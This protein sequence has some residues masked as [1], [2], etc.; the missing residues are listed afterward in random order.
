[1]SAPEE[2]AASPACA[3]QLRSISKTFG[4]QRALDHV[5]LDVRSGEI[6]A[7]MG[8]NGSGKSTVVKVLGGYHHPDTGTALVG[9]RPFQ[10]GAAKAAELAGLRFVHQDLGLV[11]DLSVADNFHLTAGRG[12]WTVPLSKKKE[13]ESAGAALREFGYD[14]DP[15]RRVESLTS[16]ERTAVAIVRAVSGGVGDPELLVL[17]EPTA[18]LPHADAEIMYGALRG[19]VAKGRSVLFISHHLDEVLALADRV[20]VLRDGRNVVTRDTNGLDSSELAALM[21]GR[22]LAADEAREHES[23]STRGRDGNPVLLVEDLRTA[24]AQGVGFE[25]YSGEIVGIAGLTGSG[26]EELAP[27]LAGQIDRQGSMTVDVVAVKPGRPR[28]ALAAG[29]QYL[30]AERRRDALFAGAS[31]R[32]NTVISN[33]DSVSRFKRVV[34]KLERTE[35]S[36]WIDVLDV[37]PGQVE[38]SA[39]ELSGG[40]QQKVVLGRLLRMDPRVLVLDEPTQG[41]DIGAKLAI[42]QLVRQVAAGGAAVVV[43]SSDESELAALANRVLV[44]KKGRIGT[45]LEGAQITAERIEEEQLAVSATASA[46]PSPRGRGLVDHE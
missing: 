5:D 7:L 38:K 8:P 43:C 3:L 17:D 35:T 34:R 19:L 41:V 30:P 14:I 15:G 22:A 11:E 40:N 39:V 16:A 26:R 24:A 44:M 31:I 28:A 32:E 20:T 10:L 6:H 29:V 13:A 42:H 1:M 27:A 23:A 36:K 45:V 46:S 12:R 2:N 37:R 33:L 4:A 18:S 9:G 21:L 25:V